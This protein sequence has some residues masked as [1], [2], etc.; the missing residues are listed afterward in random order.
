VPAGPLSLRVTEETRRR[1]EVRAK[2]ADL[3]PR[4]LAQRYLEEGL[5]MDEHPLIAFA[6]GPT[7]RRA[8]LAGHG[9]DVWEVI[10]TVRDNDG[11]VEEAAAYLQVP[12]GAVDA[13]VTYYGAH[14]EEIDTRIEANER[15]AREGLAAWEAGRAALRR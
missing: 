5:R 6:D 15:E 11:D 14:P 8:R 4:T 10:V 7:G 1:L 3:P 9:P 12:V 2:R 13:A